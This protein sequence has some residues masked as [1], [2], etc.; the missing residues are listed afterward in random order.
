VTPFHPPSQ[1][2]PPARDLVVLR[3]FRTDDADDVTAGCADPLTQR[4]LSLLPSP[5]TREDALWWINEGAPAAFAAGGTAYAM[6]DP[7]TDRV[8]GGCGYHPARS[9]AYEMGY[10]VAPWG[11]GRGVATSAARALAAEAFAAGA[12]RVFLHTDQANAASQRV[13][14]AAG[15]TREGVARGAGQRRT[16]ERYDHIVW[17]RLATDPDGPSPC[18][19]PDLPGPDGRPSRAGV[20]TDG[21]VRL[22]RLES[23]DA[24]HL[25]RLHALPEVVAT[26]VPPVPRDRPTIERRCAHAEAAWLAGDRA[27][28]TILDAATGE[29]AG[30]I[31]LFYTE[32]ATQQAMVGYSLMPEWRGRGYATRSVRLVADWALRHVGVVRVIAG[33]APDNVASQRVLLRAGF[34]RE[35]YQR[36]RLPGPDGTRVDDIVYA[37][38]P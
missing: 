15:F 26:S 36:A 25:H 10:W 37:L 31:G 5:Y 8:L 11:R 28:F 4:F 35:G 34:V 2:H 19:L 13:A 38:V 23:A 32:P 14:I 30:D 24:T 18:R 9:G 16:G 22:R 20:L 17:G 12:A 29:F 21:V 33:T 7:D 6:A 1:D 3:R 27:D